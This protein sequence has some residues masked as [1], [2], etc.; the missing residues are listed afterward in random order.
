MLRIPVLIP[1]ANSAPLLRIDGVRRALGEVAVL[2]AKRRDAFPGT[3]RW[4]IEFSGGPALLMAR[5]SGIGLGS[6][7]GGVAIRLL[8]ALR[9]L[10]LRAQGAHPHF[11]L[12]TVDRV[13]LDS[14]RVHLAGTCAP[15][16]SSATDVFSPTV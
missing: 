10:L 15:L 12:C 2:T 6:P 7:S 5:I 4:T 11:V 1:L 9:P 14:G 13:H 8:D 16:M 3:L